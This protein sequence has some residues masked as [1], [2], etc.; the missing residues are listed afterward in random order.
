MRNPYRIL[1]GESERRILRDLG[2]DG[3]ML[4]WAFKK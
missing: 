2:V 1:A 3:M 4:K